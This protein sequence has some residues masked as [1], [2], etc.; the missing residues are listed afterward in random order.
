[1]ELVS[2]LNTAS[3]IPKE[4]L[5]GH[6]AIIMDGSGRWAKNHHIP[7]VAGH[8]K[9]AGSVEEIVETFIYYGIPYLTLFAF[10]TENWNRPKEE[11][12]GILKLLEENLEYGIRIALEKKIKIHHLGSRDG[13][14][15]HIQEKIHEAT[16]LTK[17]NSNLN[18]A[19]AF[20]YGS[21]NE[22]VKALKSIVRSGAGVD[23]IDEAMIKRYL[24]TA[25]FPDPDLIIRTGGER[26][27]SNFL[28][29][30]AAYAELYFTPVLWPDFNRDE[31]EKAL[32]DYS[33][34]QRR[35]GRV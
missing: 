17:D 14:P 22:I 30:Q 27:L 12:E 23:D 20:N 19:L 10:S 31:M 34:R 15:L 33:K 16:D 1:M 3:N 9:G 18:L 26:R 6:V 28:L 7:R 35:F 29:W 4:L 5:P 24:Y 2:K 25:D 32:I 21:R 13:L 11:V 8:K